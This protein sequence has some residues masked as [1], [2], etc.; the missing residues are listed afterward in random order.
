MSEGY[1]TKFSVGDMVW[2]IEEETVY[3][4]FCKTCNSRLMDSKIKVAHKSRV[5]DIFINEHLEEYNLSYP[6]CL[7]AEKLYVTKAEAELHINE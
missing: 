1:K 4:G 2:F 6:R 3:G 5:T 7:P